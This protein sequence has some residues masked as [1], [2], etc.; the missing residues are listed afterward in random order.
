MDY[1]NC[2]WVRSN[3]IRQ[4]Q[5]EFFHVPFQAIECALSDVEVCDQSNSSVR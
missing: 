4:M 3:Y 1:G 2:E 5:D